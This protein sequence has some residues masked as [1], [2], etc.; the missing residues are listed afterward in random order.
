MKKSN[1]EFT[2]TIDGIVYNFDYQPGV[3]YGSDNDAIYKVTR[4]DQNTDQLVWSRRAIF[5][6]KATKREM[7]RQFTNTLEREKE[8]G[9][10]F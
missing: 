7:I 4:H 9:K 5:D 3:T 2:A 10:G 6:H 1:S 8:F